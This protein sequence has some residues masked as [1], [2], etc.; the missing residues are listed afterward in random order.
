MEEKKDKLPVSLIVIIVIVIIIVFIVFI[1][2]LG[3]VGANNS[4]KLPD[5]CKDTKAQARQRHAKL[6]ILIERQVALKIKL[7]KTFVRIYFAVRTGLVIIWFGILFTFYYFGLV[8]N[9]GDFLNYSEA[10]ILTLIVL[11][12]L[13]FG[14]VTNLKNYINLIKIKTENFIYGKYIDIHKKIELNKDEEER[15]RKELE[16]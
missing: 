7:D 1:I 15:L 6:K 12:F 9:L 10:S 11:N 3:N 2:S 16:S 5:E 14:N 13:T 4:Q 8:N